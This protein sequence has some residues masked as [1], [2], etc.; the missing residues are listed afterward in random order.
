M[1]P[2]AF[3]LTSVLLLAPGSARAVERSPYRH[4][5]STQEH[6]EILLDDGTRRSPTFAALRETLESA[7]II[8]YVQTVGNLPDSLDGRLAFLH[9]ANGK[10]YLRIEVRRMLGRAQMLSTI[11]HELQH[12]VEIAG[13]T[14]VRDSASMAGFYRRVGVGGATRAGFDTRAA[15]E[16]GR[17]VRSELSGV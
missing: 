13:A 11:G 15:R 10:R 3:L 4:V 16:T 7:D 17:R 6:V 8:V 1:R 5:R 12:A 9:A 14:E 2:I